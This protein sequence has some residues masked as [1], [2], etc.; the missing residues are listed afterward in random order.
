[1]TIDEDTR[2]LLRMIRNAEAKLATLA[3]GGDSPF[4]AAANTAMTEDIARMKAQVFDA[5]RPQ[6]EDAAK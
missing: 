5:L 3:S 2:L 1:M 4:R 6:I